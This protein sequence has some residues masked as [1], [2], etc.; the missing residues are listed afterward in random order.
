MP[1]LLLALMLIPLPVRTQ[2]KSFYPEVPGTVQGFP[3][4]DYRIVILTKRTGPLWLPVWREQFLR[5]DP[6]C[7]SGSRQG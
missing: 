3:V 2:E 7:E 4:Y 6:R 5:A 1:W